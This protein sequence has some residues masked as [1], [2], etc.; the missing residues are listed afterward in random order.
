V[1]AEFLG[2]VASRA[3]EMTVGDPIAAGVRMGPVI[4]AAARDSITASVAAAVGAGARPLTDRSLQLPGD[5]ADG[6][7]VAPTV[8][9]CT[10]VDVSLWN[11]ELFGPVLAAR[12]V[13][14]TEEA[15]ALANAGEFGLSAAVFTNDLGIALGAIDAINVGMLHINSETAGADPHV[16]FGGAKGSALGPQ[17]QGAAAREFY[18]HP[19]TVYL[20]GGA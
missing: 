9:D 12:S 11:D 4:T 14:S 1:S 13:A 17:E 16:P 7:F 2:A 18:T 5:L 15:F 20:R 10:G 6:H 3:D 8:L 19:T